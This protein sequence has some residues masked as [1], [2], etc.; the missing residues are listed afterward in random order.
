MQDCSTDFEFLPI[1]VSLARCQRYFQTI[2]AYSVTG[3][4]ASATQ[5]LLGCPVRVEFR[6]NSSLSVPSSLTN[7]VDEWPVAPRTPTS[8]N[9]FSGTTENVVL[10]LSG[11]TGGTVGGTIILQINGFQLSAEL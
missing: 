8:V 5:G 4:M 6:A 3:N 7:M 10:A 2:S 11:M 9:I 1:D